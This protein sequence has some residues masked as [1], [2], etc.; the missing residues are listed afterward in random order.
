MTPSIAFRHDPQFE[1]RSRGN[2]LADANRRT[3]WIRRLR[4]FILDSNEV[5]EMPPELNVIR[6]QVDDVAKAES[7]RTEMRCDEPKR[8]SEL[9]GRIRG[10][11]AIGA[12]PCYP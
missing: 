7:R 1:Q 9:L 6:S 5:G 3:R 11:G 8:I 4:V 10:H 2:Q 12:H